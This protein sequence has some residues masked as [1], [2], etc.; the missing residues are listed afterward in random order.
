MWILNISSGSKGIQIHSHLVRK[1]SL[2][3]LAKLATLAKWLSNGLRTKW[4]CVRIPLLSL[5]LQVSRLFWARKHSGKKEKFKFLDTQETI[6][7]R[8]TLK[9]VRD[10]VYSLHTDSHWAPM[11]P[12]KPQ[13][14]PMN[15]TESQGSPLSSSE[16]QWPLLTPSDLHWAPVS[17]TEP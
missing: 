6:E 2:N 8:F 4:L 9:D 3:H 17:S 7:C 16:P 10:G 12:T 11:T 5:K 14:A 15:P 1:R 13:R